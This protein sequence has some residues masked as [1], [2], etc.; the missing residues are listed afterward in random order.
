MRWILTLLFLALATRAIA[1]DGVLEINQTCAAQTGCFAGD[2][3]GYPVTIATLGSYRLTGNLILPNENT[4]GIVV[5]ATDVSID[6]GGFTI[7]GP[8]QCSAPPVVCQLTGTGEGIYGQVDRLRVSNGSI[9]G[10]GAVGI[11]IQLHGAGYDFRNLLVAHNRYGGMQ[12]DGDAAAVEGVTVMRNGGS[13]ISVL[14]A[15]RVSGN[16]VFQNGSH[17][18]SAASGATISGNNVFN[19]AGIGIVTNGDS[20]IQENTVAV[21]GSF[22]LVPGTNSGYRANTISNNANNNPATGVNAGANVC[23]GSLGCAP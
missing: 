19:N 11:H 21:N 10:L 14:F 20:T 16:T 13:G 23:Q 9:V 6:L 1:S 4:T 2:A 17:G 15:A 22:G 12:I 18:I 7:R 5:T 3:A 8:N